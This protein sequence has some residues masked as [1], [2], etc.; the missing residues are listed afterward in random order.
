MDVMKVSSGIV[1]GDR[2]E[3][4]EEVLEKDPELAVIIIVGVSCFSFLQNELIGRQV[5][6]GAIH[7]RGAPFFNALIKLLLNVGIL[8]PDN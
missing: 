3:K 5:V 7:C 2:V 4:G 1:D 6:G 8:V